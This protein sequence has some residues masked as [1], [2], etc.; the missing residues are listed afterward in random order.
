M[1]DPTT[2]LGIEYLLSA[3]IVSFHFNDQ[4]NLSGEAIVSTHFTHFTFIKISDEFDGHFRD[5]LYR[6]K[7]IENLILTQ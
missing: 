6:E 1:T 3:F 5:M 2:P 4:P 7:Y